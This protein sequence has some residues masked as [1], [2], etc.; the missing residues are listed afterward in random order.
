M[1]QS[2]FQTYIQTYLVNLKQ[3]T[4]NISLLYRN[5]LHWNISKICI[6]LYVNIAGFILSLPFIIALVVQY[7]QKYSSLLTGVDIYTFLD[8]NFGTVL[9]SILLFLIIVAIFISTYTYGYFLLLNVY[10]GYLQDEKLPY[11]K[12]LYL[13]W[14]H[15]STYLGVLGWASLYLLLPIVL[16]LVVAIPFG[17]ALRM[18]LLGSLTS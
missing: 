11:T 9:L 13:S 15:F 17:V 7:F 2:L 10:K 16:L 8:Q 4:H 12:N 6:F 3:I 14:K 1:F 5:F 18:D